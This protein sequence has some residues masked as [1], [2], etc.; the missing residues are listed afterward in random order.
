MVNGEPVADLDINYLWDLDYEYA[1]D[2]MKLTILRNGE[3]FVLNVTLGKKPRWIDR[4]F[5]ILN[6]TPFAWF[7]ET[8]ISVLRLSI[9]KKSSNEF[10]FSFTGMN[11]TRE[12][13]CK[14][15]LSQISI[16]DDLGIP[17]AA[18]LI[19]ITI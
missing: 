2:N 8:E 13:G 4:E 1:G 17:I 12:E 10:L 15:D 5:E 9:L 11:Y 18:R 6:Q 7:T 19:P 3:T 14:L 16:V